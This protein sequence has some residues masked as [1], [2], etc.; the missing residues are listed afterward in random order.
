M[1]TTPSALPVGRPRGLSQGNTVLF[2]LCTF[3]GFVIHSGMRRPRESSSSN[4][5]VPPCSVQ[6]S[7]LS[8]TR[9]PAKRPKTSQACVSC[10]KHKTRCELLDSEI[11]SR[12]HRCDVLSITCSFETNAPPTQA[13][14]Y[15]PSHR[16]VVRQ[17]LLNAILSNPQSNS[18]KCLE[19][20]PSDTRCSSPR[21]T[22][23]SPWELLKVPGIPDWSVTPMLAMLTLSKMAR[24]EQPMI[25]PVSNLTFAEVLT[26]DQRQYLLRLCVVILS[27]SFSCR[28]SHFTSFESHYAPWL[29][30]P[31]NAL[32]DDP[33][34]N[35]IRCTIASRHL[36]S[37]IHAVV[38]P[39]LRRL[40]EEAIVEHIFNP[41]PSPATIQS[42]ALL[43]LWSP[44]DTSSSSSSETRDSRLIAAA[45][46]NMCST[47]RCDQAATDEEVLQERRKLGTELTS[48]EVALLTTAEQKKLLVSS[49]IFY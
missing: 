1:M 40:T 18:D 48:Q 25:Q 38:F 4:T 47:L 30:L 31:P 16:S 5:A 3:I 33:V 41:S 10:R 2:S 37:S 6:P 19:Q 43:A 45:A 24:T 23:T 28:H 42:F 20:T 21:S 32:E 12:C 27:R 22:A 11:R 44:F 9:P 17:R 35:L 26:G 13:A 15:S 46:I 34:L 39:T 49:P 29:S 14:E 8:T 7:D 36:E